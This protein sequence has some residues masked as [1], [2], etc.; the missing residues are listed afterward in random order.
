[1]PQLTREQLWSELKAG[2]IGPAYLLFGEERYLR[3]RAA[4]AIADHALAGCGLREFNEN[5]FSLNDSDAVPEILAAADQLPMMSA[6]RVLL[7]RDLR[8]TATAKGDSLRE[9]HEDRLRSYF[10]RPAETTVI[11]FVAD[12]FDKRRRMAKL[13]LDN[14]VSV[15]FSRLEAADLANWARKEM[16]SAGFDIDERTLH[17][18]V[19]L[20]GNEMQ[21]LENEIKKVTTASL[22][23]RI[24][25]V[26]TIDALVPSSRVLSNFDLTDQ[27]FSKDKART[28]ET[29]K[30]ILDDGAEPLM[31][32]G[33]IATSFRRLLKAK[34]MMVNG[35]E[36]REVARVLGLPYRRQEEFLAIARRSDRAHLV[37]ALR[38][39]S[40]TDLAIKTSRGGGGPAGTR[41]QIEILITELAASVNG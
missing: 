5:V 30:K 32:L 18:F 7:V 9:A 38:R 40:D 29:L 26:E 15:E 11:I 27:L 24:V 31:L 4:S 34:E 33:L 3:D 35:V 10:E 28:F 13:L 6:K 21:R 36:R 25:T 20:V 37:G 17:Y 23:D 16:K 39:I 14:A 19:G 2:S 8:V 12:E 41:L 1:M 22:P